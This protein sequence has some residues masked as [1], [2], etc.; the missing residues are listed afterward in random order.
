MK[1]SRPTNSNNTVSQLTRLVS[2]A[3]VKVEDQNRQIAALKNQV[4]AMEAKADRKVISVP[5]IPP[6]RSNLDSNLMLGRVRA[7]DLSPLNQS[8]IQSNIQG[9]VRGNGII[10]NHQILTLVEPDNDSEFSLPSTIAE[11]KQEDDDNE[12]SLFNPA[13]Q[14]QQLPI[15]VQLQITNVED[16]LEFINGHLCAICH[17][18]IQVGFKCIYPSCQG[19]CC[20]K[21]VINPG[22]NLNRC[23]SCRR[24]EDHEIYFA[25]TQRRNAMIILMANYL[26]DLA[27]GVAREHFRGN[28]NPLSVRMHRLAH[29]FPFGIVTQN[30]SQMGDN[31]SISFTCNWFRFD[32]ESHFENDLFGELVITVGEEFT[33]EVTRPWLIL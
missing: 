30:F 4:E 9:I 12:F 27:F 11:V 7:R 3:I 22:F 16:K 29:Y 23:H 2:N 32:V 25:S 31:I 1:K 10:R 5:S 28:E 21:C 13:N 8:N 14:Q 15:P 20:P 33:I 18:Q 6:P 24:Y 19:M 17:D 26:M